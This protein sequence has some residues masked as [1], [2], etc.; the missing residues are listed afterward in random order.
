METVFFSIMSNKSTLLFNASTPLVSLLYKND[1]FLK[2]LFVLAG[3]SFI[4]TLTLPYQGEEAVYTITSLEMWFHQEWIK[5]IFYGSNYGRPPLFNWLIIPLAS[6]LGWEQ[7]LLASRLI[8]ATATLCSSLVLFWLM[9]QLFTEKKIAWLASV[10]FLSGDL[11]FRRG[12]LA[13]ADPLFSLFVFS[14]ICFLWVGL[15]KK[16]VWL[17]ALA[18]LCLIAAFLSKALTAYCFYGIAFLVLFWRHQNRRFL[19]SPLSIIFHLA[20]LL[21]PLFWNMALSEGAHGSEM[22]ID[23]FSRLSPSELKHYIFKVMAYPFYTLFHWLPVSGLLLYVFW[24]KKKHNISFLSQL[25]QQNTSFTLLQIAFWIL[26]LNYLPYWLAPQNRIRYILPL[27]PFFALLA[28]YVLYQAGEQ[29]VKFLSVLLGVLV[30]VKFVFG[31]YGFAFIEKNVRGDYVSTAKDIIQKT[32]GYPLYI[33]DDTANGLSVTAEIDVLRLPLA[34]L[35][36]SANLNE[37]K[38]QKDAF[39]LI[40]D[41]SQYPDAK[42]FDEYALG[43]H[44]L[45]LVCRGKACHKHL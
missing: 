14:A 38:K 35:T 4:T 19:F 42:L 39:Y 2:I 28:A 5:P 33:D 27:Y 1:V 20:G 6:F 12:W 8:A 30:L 37:R 9:R 11:L 43:R 17:F 26:L 45:Y 41:L 7:V 21:F 32:K 3:F 13:Y 44:K 34:P 16:R 15:E 25:K 40:E 18:N 36:R 23:I 31:L 22:I 10:I 24:Q 29:I